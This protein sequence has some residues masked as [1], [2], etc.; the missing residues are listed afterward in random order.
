MP[1]PEIIFCFSEIQEMKF[2]LR[3]C[4]M[5]SKGSYSGTTLQPFQGLCQ[6]NLG[7]PEGWFLISCTLIIYLKQKGHGVGIKTV[8]T[9]DD[10]KLMTMMFFENG[11]FTNFG[12]ITYSQ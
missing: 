1:F 10:F 2:Y 11:N 4:F 12:K 7:A 5:D 3:T 6:I 9:G 8:I